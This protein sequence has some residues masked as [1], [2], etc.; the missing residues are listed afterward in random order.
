MPTSIESSKSSTKK[1]WS[2]YGYVLFLIG[3]I[4]YL[5]QAIA[6]WK[7][8]LEK[9][10]ISDYIGCIADSIFVVESFIYMLGWYVVRDNDSKFF[11]LDFNFWGNMHIYF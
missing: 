1:D 9:Y 10:S 3:S 6:P 4:L 11:M 2:I 7:S 5:I 8:E